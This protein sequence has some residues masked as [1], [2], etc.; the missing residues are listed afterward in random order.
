MR[1][2]ILFC[3][4]F[5]LSSCVSMMVDNSVAPPPVAVQK[6]DLHVDA[7]YAILPLSNNSNAYTLSAVT[8]GVGYAISDVD[9]VYV[10]GTVSTDFFRGYSAKG[11][12][13][14]RYLRKLNRTGSIEHFAGGQV[15]YLGSQTGIEDPFVGSNAMGVGL[16]YVGRINSPGPVQAY[17]SVHGGYGGNVDGLNYDMM[18]GTVAL[19]IQ[20]RP[21]RWLEVRGELSHSGLYHPTG[22]F[23]YDLGGFNVNVRYVF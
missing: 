20:Y 6:G 15:Q 13:S 21:W 2:L 16:M 17:G 12:A 7:G 8:G 9:H 4:L 18:I 19:G 10:N 22:D 14:A 23:G 1:Y 5:F 11:T 3:S